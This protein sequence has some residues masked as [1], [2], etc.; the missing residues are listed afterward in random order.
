MF[1]YPKRCLPAIPTTAVSTTTNAILLHSHPSLYIGI[2]GSRV[3]V[4]CLGIH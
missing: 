4:L 1:R 3:A 2:H